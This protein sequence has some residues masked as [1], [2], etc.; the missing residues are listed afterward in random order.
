MVPE[1]L[2]GTRKDTFGVRDDDEDESKCV[3]KSLHYAYNHLCE[4]GYD[5]EQAQRL[6]IVAV[7]RT[8]LAS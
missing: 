1:S 8:L 3:D 5:K 6:A 4:R 7:A 2:E